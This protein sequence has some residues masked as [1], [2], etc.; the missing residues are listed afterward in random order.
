MDWKNKCA[1]CR[2][3]ARELG[4]AFL[5]ACGKAREKTGAALGKAK[6]GLGR[7]AAQTRV[8][9]RKVW[10]KTNGGLTRAWNWTREK[11]ARFWEWLKPGLEWSRLWFLKAKEKLA[12]L[13]SLLG[14]HCRVLAGKLAVLALKVRKW[15]LK[16]TAKLRAWWSGCKLRNWLAAKAEARRA[17]LPPAEETVEEEAPLVLEEGIDEEALEIAEEPVRRKAPARELS[18]PVLILLAV[19]KIIKNTVV[20][21]WRLRKYIMAAPV[22]FVAVKLAIQNANRLPDMVGLDIQ[23]SGEFAR[24][25]TRQHA[26][27]GPLGVTAFCLV[28]VLCSRKPLLP[29]LISI[30]TLLLPVLIWMTNLYA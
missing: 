23:A 15:V 1:Q 2:E 20:W 27:L 13:F 21:I 4:S 18:K 3:K 22:A 29:W 10:N 30:F 25:V 14:E 19:W 28:L 7:T 9:L 5:S 26:V 11:L 16:K 17:K 8:W 6:T 24:M 12:K